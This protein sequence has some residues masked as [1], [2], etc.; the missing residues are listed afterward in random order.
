[1]NESQERTGRWSL[2]DEWKQLCL[3]FEAGKFFSSLLVHLS[4]LTALLQ[5]Q[6]LAR[7]KTMDQALV[8]LESLLPKTA[9]GGH[10]AIG[11]HRGHK[12][13]LRSKGAF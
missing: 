7:W 10:S 1:M 4:A 8:V 2:L 11:H 3:N 9:R 5:R 6:L 13:G 12:I